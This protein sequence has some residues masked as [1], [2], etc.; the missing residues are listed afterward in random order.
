MSPTQARAKR[1]FDFVIAACGLLLTGWLILICALLAT[2]D[3]RASGFFM[4][5]RVGRHGKLFRVVKLRTM[6]QDSTQTTTVTTVHDSRITTLG[7]ILRRSKIDELPQLWNVLC[8]QMSLVG[9]RPDVPGYADALDGEARA[10]LE[11]RPGIT[12]PAS[13]AFR[14]EE[15]LLA[16]AED[17]ESYND[18]IIWPAKVAWN[19][20]YLR[21]YRLGRDLA[22]LLA[23]VSRR[24][25]LRTFPELS[26]PLEPPS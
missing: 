1:A 19:L 9:P 2:I 4:Q 12:G 20:D 3:T 26:R 23:T 10:L 22:Y 16:E 21:R 14:D 11:L 25:Q 8:G 18:S 6:R 7:R 15:L 5:R 13:L 24:F 17:P